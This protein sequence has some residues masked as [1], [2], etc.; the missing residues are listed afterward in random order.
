MSFIIP[1]DIENRGIRFIQ[2]PHFQACYILE[3]I[4]TRLN[5]YNGTEDG[6]LDKLSFPGTFVL[7]TMR[8]DTQTTVNKRVSEIVGHTI[9][10][11][12]IVVPMEMLEGTLCTNP[13]CFKSTQVICDVC[14]WTKYCSFS[15]MT[16]DEHTS[17]CIE[18]DELSK[19]RIEKL[20]NCLT[21]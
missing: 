20:K 16:N 8:Y 15:C 6:K 18:L 13:S 4:Q 11:N 12:V 14:C 19:Q 1:T 2:P 9:Y 7:F 5:D 17:R 10:G 21:L 3:E